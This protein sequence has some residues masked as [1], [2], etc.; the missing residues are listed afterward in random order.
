M[1][2]NAD[3]D[4]GAAA[5]I[6]ESRDAGAETYEVD[7]SLNHLKRGAGPGLGL[8]L[9]V[10]TGAHLDSDND[11][12]RGKRRLSEAGGA[13]G[14]AG[15][16][17]AADALPLSGDADADWDALLA[18]PPSARSRA[19]GVSGLRDRLSIS[20]G[21]MS[22][23]SIAPTGSLPRVSSVPRMS[24][25]SGSS[26]S[27]GGPGQ[28]QR[29][30]SRGNA[31]ALATSP[32][33][34]AIRQS[35]LA[36]DGH[37]KG[38]GGSKAFLKQNGS[39]KPCAGCCSKGSRS[40]KTYVKPYTTSVRPLLGLIARY[41]TP[42]VILWALLTVLFWQASHNLSLTLTTSSI[43]LASKTRGLLILD[44]TMQTRALI[45]AP[46][47][48]EDVLEA[49]A[50]VAATTT[51]LQY[52]HRL[53]A[54]G[55]LPASE[56]LAGAADAAMHSGGKGGELLASD[57]AST[58]DSVLYGNACEALFNHD[59]AAFPSELVDMD[60]LQ[61]RS[62][63]GSPGE[64]YSGTV[65][66][67]GANR[68][69]CVSVMSGSLTTGGLHA[70]L[71][72]FIRLAAAA[73][74]RRVAATVP[75]PAGTQT[76]IGFVLAGGESLA[77]AMMPVVTGQTVGN[78]TTLAANGATLDSLL[79]LAAAGNGTLPPWNYSSV[80][81]SPGVELR[82]EALRALREVGL[83]YLMQGSSFVADEYAAAGE[84]TR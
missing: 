65:A 17:S 78:M 50:A 67:I 32:G 2:T 52:L 66:V 54:F 80:P 84:L 71:R 36:A 75:Y 64:W 28:L 23:A 22:S 73:S 43:D 68:S 35:A 55:G 42:L 60:A 13:G 5:A 8:G 47:T 25:S 74:L 7:N 15:G 77:V 29:T 38:Y 41:M 11:A 48:P 18:G 40:H 79:Q 56:E 44:L 4:D 39:S 57:A 21:S 3:D 19:T 45:A 59:Y 9:G 30:N 33:S 72:D 53:L 49:A 26:G 82:S 69:D 81:Y 37:G 10:G 61:L 1:A 46:G 6:D 20:T 31:L 83:R 14:A 51:D 62:D 70:G 76:Q 16:G 58:I 24:A 27:G 34:G 63:G 12:T